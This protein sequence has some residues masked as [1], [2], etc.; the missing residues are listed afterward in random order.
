MGEVYLASDATLGRN[1]ALKILPVEMADDPDHLQ[2]FKREARAVAALNH[3][4][5]VTVHSVEE[6]Q[7]THFIT[8]EY[9]EGRTLAELIPPNGLPIQ[10][11]L[12]I[13]IQIA[14]ALFAA[15]ER[16][17]VHRD[18]KPANIMVSHEQTIKILDF[19]LAKL[20]TQ[21]IAAPPAGANPLTQEGMMVGTPQYMSPEQLLAK[22]I[23][24]RTDIFSFGVLMYEMLTGRLPFHGSTWAE[25]VTS[26]LR[27]SPPSLESVRTGVPP[28]IGRIIFRCLQKNPEDRYKTAREISAELKGLLGSGSHFAPAMGLNSG[29]ITRAKSDGRVSIAVLYFESLDRSAEQE[30]F[31]DGMTE[32]IITELCKIKDLIVFPRSMVASFRNRPDSV[33]QVGRQLNA[34]FVLEGSIRCAG[35]RLRVTARLVEVGSG[36]STWSERYDRELKDVFDV[37][38]EIARSIAQALR[39]NL[40]PQEE[41][42]IALKPTKNP[43]AYDSYLRG[44]NFMRRTNRQ[45]LECALQMFEQAISIE[46]SFA[47]AHA[48]IAYV[49]GMIYDWYEKDSSW[50]DRGD[51]ASD[52]ALELQPDLPE[53]LSAR[54]RIFWAQSRYEDTIRLSQMAIQRKRDC[55]GAHWTLGAALFALDRLDEVAA[56]VDQ[57]L[58]AAGDDYNTYNPYRMA[59]EKLGQKEKARRIRDQWARVLKRHL[60]QIPDDARA[61]V[62]LA[63]YH[64][65]ENNPRDAITEI[66]K[67]VALRPDP[68]ILYNAACA[69]GMLN[70]KKETLE[71]LKKATA[72]G[73]PKLDW[74]ARDPDFACIRD[75]PEFQQ[76]LQ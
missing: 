43:E 30:Y 55:E 18:L 54:A 2:R 26:I 7:G 12:E 48:G 29:A 56:L 27:D 46:P 58:E 60:E 45:D 32:D 38:D 39:I 64:A 4:N 23:Q 63:Q 53:A 51:R 67:A 1:V 71:Y 19:G 49:C 36:H 62:M 31:R 20:T 9:L 52:R 59:L 41:Q 57:A 66:E 15:H 3:P 73:F 35:N 42:A 50:I 75:D 6:S 16:G 33:S 34:T 28:E 24:H 47:L 65:G 22:S 11:F 14:G 40:S 44:R 68:N 5:I 69:Y 13:S 37:Q 70:L 17:I 21:E 8:M 76:L 25:L 72:A 74:I 10:E 61:H